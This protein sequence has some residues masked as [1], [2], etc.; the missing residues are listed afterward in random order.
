[1]IVLRMGTKR[2]EV[3]MESPTTSGTKVV[4]LRG[5]IRG[6]GEGKKGTAMR[7][8]SARR[9]A[10]GNSS[11]FLTLGSPPDLPIASL[12]VKKKG[13]ERPPSPGKSPRTAP[14]RPAHRDLGDKQ[15]FHLVY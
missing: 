1:M 15:V 8:S 14:P 5:L 4:P 11:P 9:G 7:G 10:L 13:G 12:H 2:Q 6:N 3:R